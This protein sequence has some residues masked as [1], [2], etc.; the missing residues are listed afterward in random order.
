MSSKNAD[1]IVTSEDFRDK[2]ARKDNVVYVRN[3]VS[4]PEVKE[5]MKEYLEAKGLL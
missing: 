3:V 2:F 1:L 5:K 4:T